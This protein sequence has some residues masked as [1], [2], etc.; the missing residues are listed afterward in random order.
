MKNNKKP[1]V[2]VVMP[3]FTHK[4]YQLKAAIKSILNQTYKNIELIIVDGSSTSKNYNTIKCFSDNRIFYYKAKGY[5]N[6]LN[7]GIAKSKGEYIARMDSDDISY[8]TRIEEQYNFLLK[9]KD[10]DM[11]S[12]QVRL[13]GDIP[14][15]KKITSFPQ[16][17]EFIPFIKRHTIIHPAI[18][19]RRNLDIKY[20]NF[21]P[22]EDCYLF[23][24]LLCKGVKIANLNKVLYSYRVNSNSIMRRY[25][26]HCQFRSLKF[27]VY[28]LGKY[29]N[30][31]LIFHEEVFK[32][33]KFCYEEL[34]DFLK[35]SQNLSKKLEDELDTYKL[36]Y[37]YFKYMI[38]NLTG[39]SFGYIGILFNPQVFQYRQMI[40][41][42]YISP[43]LRFCFQVGNEY[44][45]D[46]K[47]KF[48]TIFGK[49]FPLKFF[50]R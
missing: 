46:K 47:T 28:F 16:N 42:E 15:S 2:S 29:T 45:K 12:V 34:V 31:N 24:D 40:R 49:K 1:L 38:S 36:F 19:F 50:S 7:L 48:L 4:E 13:F 8:R 33:S 41:K 25:S 44:E 9:N 10:I 22:L 43:I 6:C 37:P 35:Y 30:E 20:S 32:K 5:I 39:F 23:R 14:S 17:I 27:N 11:C 21:M 18:M 3:I 26:K